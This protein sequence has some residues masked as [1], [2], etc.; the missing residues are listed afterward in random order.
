MIRFTIYFVLA[1]V[2]IVSAGA[3]EVENIPNVHVA[4]RTRFLS[5]PDGIISPRA[6]A[7]A[8]SMMSAVW[9]ETTAE[10]VAVVVKSIGDDDINE[11]ATRLFTEWGIGKKDRDNGVL[12]LIV[13]DSRKMV[14][15]T[16][17]GAEGALPDIVAGRIIRDR[18][19]PLF[20]EGDV[21]GGLLAG[22]SDIC[23]VLSDE[24]VADE[25]KSRYSGDSGSSEEMS[26]GELMTSIGIWG[27][28][29]LV[30][31]L[32]V[33]SITVSKSRNLSH[34]KQYSN[35]RNL[36]VGA[37]AVTA[38]GL[39]IPVIAYL[40]ARHLKN[41]AR[42]TPPECE[43]CHGLMRRLDIRQGAHYLTPQQQTEQRIGSVDYDVW[44][45]PA[46]GK[47][48]VIAYPGRNSGFT[49]CQVCGA[50]ACKV[51]SRQT[52]HHPTRYRSGAGVETTTC[53]H[54][55]NKTYR[56]YS[57]AKLAAPVVVAGGIGGGRGFGGGGFG[58]GSFGGG[59]TG[60]G[61]ASGGW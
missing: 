11:F 47:T 40:I 20:R 48:E 53:L 9:R 58:G 55:G 24:K 31:M 56:K 49:V 1:V 19:A 60:G 6:Q 13:M 29:L 14:I 38:A 33:I 26:V 12:L 22:V 51:T 54:C 7:A 30:L 50:K 10:P 5:N 35:Y 61:G 17:Y 2:S 16:G 23:G 18:I 43:I 59:S 27:C 42:N 15:R 25:L 28:V 52:V 4:D 34:A 21:D 41:K 39:G 44:R 37:L 36:S 32:L 8:D 57:I 3:Y 45:C 46:D